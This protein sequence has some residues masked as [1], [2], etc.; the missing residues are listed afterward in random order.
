[1]L[2]LLDFVNSYSSTCKMF[3]FYYSFTQCLIWMR[4]WCLCMWIIRE[5]S[6]QVPFNSELT[7]LCMITVNETLFYVKVMFQVLCHKL[8][9]WF[10]FSFVSILYTLVTVYS[11]DRMYKGLC[12]LSPSLQAVL[13]LVYC[14]HRTLYTC[15]QG[16]VYFKSLFVS[17]TLIG[18]L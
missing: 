10:L 4:S 16:L 1:M 15:M 14:R 12:I 11:T 3:F 18:L 6:K 2:Q 17:C 9:F 8:Y 7:N 5:V 13:L